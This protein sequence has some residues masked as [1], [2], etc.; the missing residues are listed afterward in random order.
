MIIYNLYWVQDFCLI[1]C[2]R[3]LKNCLETSLWSVDYCDHF[4][5]GQKLRLWEMNTL[6]KTMP[7][8]QPGPTS[9]CPQAHVYLTLRWQFPEVIIFFIPPLTSSCISFQR[10]SS[11]TNKKESRKVLSES[12][13][14]MSGT[15]AWCGWAGNLSLDL[16]NHSLKVEI[17]MSGQGGLLGRL[18]CLE[19][20]TSLEDVWIVIMPCLAA[21][22][23][24]FKQKFLQWLFSNLHPFLCFKI[25]ATI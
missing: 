5:T 2:K 11:K 19:N 24:S 14:I 25:T 21:K 20:L 15:L 22:R 18:S 8:A 23:T 12:Q 13:Q 16:S 3:L 4:F 9:R 6:S 1:P 10:R 17:C 7:V